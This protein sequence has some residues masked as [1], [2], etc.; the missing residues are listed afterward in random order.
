[1]ADGFDLDRF[2]V[3]QEHDY[4][5]ALAELRA[6]RKR[7]HWVWFVLPQ[8]RG[9]GTSPTAQHYGIE[10]L[11]EARAY[12]AHP[13]LGP[14]LVACAQALLDQPAER[15]A[16]AI[17]GGIDAVK[18]RS[19]MTLFTTA[20]PQRPEFPAV[21]ERYFGGVPDRLTLGMLGAG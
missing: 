11:A 20:D 13:V 15:S 2:V 5:R 8:L 9:L 21:L 18:L 14:R 4:S 7:G 3:A 17:L 19:S 10:S 12:L 6:G 1:M 16:E